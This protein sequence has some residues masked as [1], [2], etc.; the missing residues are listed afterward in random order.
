M[1]Q[2]KIGVIGVTG[3]GVLWKH[4]HKPEGK[5]IVAGG[6]DISEDALQKFKSEIKEKVFTTLDYKELLKRKDIDAIAVMTPDFTHEEYAVAALNAGKHVFLEKPMAITTEGCDNILK[7]WKQSGKKLMIGFNMRHMRIFQTMKDIADTG[8][9]GEIKAVWVRHFVGRGGAWYFRTWMSERKNSTGLLLQK[10]AHDIDM[11]HWITGSYTKKVAAFGSLDFYG[12]NKPN[13]LTC[14]ECSEK[15]T[16]T[17]FESDKHSIK[18]AFRKAIDVE[19]NSVM[20]MELENGI[21][22]SY[23]QCHFSPDYWRNYTF[24]GTEGRMENLDDTSKVIVK[25][26]RSGKWKEFSDRTYDLKPVEGGHGGADPVISKDFVDMLLTGKEPVS[27][28]EAG[29]MSVATGCAATE[30]LRNGGK[31]MYIPLMPDLV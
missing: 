19:D 25:T 4:W 22:A 23:E 24:I 20:I 11:I 14:P 31:M 16:C 26:R 28:P 7:A 1:K 8:T 12:G 13:D 15:E 18:C 3:R 5:S 21:K 6:A 2:V 9:I 10:A 27:T 30:S 17:E 29:R